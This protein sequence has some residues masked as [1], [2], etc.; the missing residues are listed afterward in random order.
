MLSE[1]KNLRLILGSSS[2]RRL[3]LLKQINGYPHKIF[4]PEINE[5]P[6]KKTVQNIANIGTIFFIN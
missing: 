3:D 4:N 2:P 5:D 6:Q 1:N